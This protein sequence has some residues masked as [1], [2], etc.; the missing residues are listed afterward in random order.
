[1]RYLA[2][3]ALLILTLPGCTREIGW[4]E[5][6]TVTVVYDPGYVACTT[7][8]RTDRGMVLTRRG[9]LATVGDRLCVQ[10]YQRAVLGS[11]GTYYWDPSWQCGIDRGGPHDQ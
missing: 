9:C 6:A 7:S 5:W 8:V 10:G 2:I 3:C 11:Q 4:P 1:M